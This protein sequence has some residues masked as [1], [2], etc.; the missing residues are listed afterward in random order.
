MTK[1]S[2]LLVLFLTVLSLL[3]G[4]NYFFKPFAFL[5]ERQ[6]RLV[7]ASPSPT[8]SPQ[9]SDVEVRIGEMSTEQRIAQLL[10]VSVVVDQ[11]FTDPTVATQSTQL[12][13][14]QSNQPGTAIL[15][16]S[17]VSTEAATVITELIVSNNELSIQ[18]LVA[19]DHEGGNVQRLSGAGFSPLQSW[20]ELCRDNRVDAQVQLEQSIEQVTAVGIDVIFGPVVDVAARNLALGSRVCSGDFE[21][22][23]ERA[24][25]AASVYQQNNILPV[26][27]HFPGIGQTTVDLHNDF[28]TI[29]VSEEEAKL[30]RE[31]LQD[32]QDEYIGVMVAHV[33]VENQDPSLPC[34]LSQSC[35]G[36]IA[37]NF[38]QTLIFSDDILMESAK[39]E[40]AGQQQSNSGADS[41]AEEV[42]IAG[43][44]LDA[45]L[46]GNHQV[47]I[48]PGLDPQTLTQA[49]DRLEAIYESN[50]VVKDRIDQSLKT[51]LRYKQDIGKIE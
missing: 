39:G 48:G 24:R 44:I 27:K 1:Q 50:S 37:D 15:F 4:Y 2:L 36:Q 17:R 38:P 40:N 46:A 12:Q 28:D 20:V 13:W 43:I 5:E 42:Q 51:V 45:I 21:L 35:V 14:I 9:V 34:S 47:L 26:F 33:G 18:P 32:Y 8:P 6:E 7:Q 31:L 11:S 22:V 16:G 25:L 3:L 19:V 30:F 29:R 41:Q 10:A 49:I 23:A